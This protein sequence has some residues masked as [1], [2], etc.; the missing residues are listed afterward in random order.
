M[1]DDGT[2]TLSCFWNGDQL[3]IYHP[4]VLSGAVQSMMSLPFSTTATGVTL[5]AFSYTV[6]GAY[7]YNPSARLY[8]F[9][10][11]TIGGY[12]A[13]AADDGTSTLKATTL[14]NQLGTL[15]DCAK[16]DA[17]YGSA[18]VDFG[19]GLPGS[20]TMHH[21]FGM[22]NLH[23]TSS[24]FSTSY[25]VTV[26][27]TSSANNILPGNSGSA[28]L[29]ADGITLTRT[30]SW[31]ANWSATVTPTT[32]GVVDV[33]LMTWPFSGTTGTLT[34]SCSD[35]SGSTYTPRTVT[36]S[37]FSLAAA[38]VKSKPL[39][40]TN[41]LTPPVTTYSKVYAWDATDYQPNPVGSIPTNA[42]T[43]VTC[44]DYFNHAS[45]ACKNCPN[46]N[47]L[48]WYLSVPC[49]WDNGTINGG[50]RTRY[51]RPDGNYTKIGMWIRKKSGIPG[52]SSTTSSGVMS[53]GSIDLSTMSTAAIVA[54]NL[55]KN[56]FF[57]PAVG[58]TNADDN[59]YYDAD[60]SGDYWTSTPCSYS[61][62]A[63]HLHF[64]NAGVYFSY[65]NRICGFCLWQAQ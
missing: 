54:L 7:R 61:A 49:Y 39:A 21:L 28:I 42:N 19:T 4:Y 46:A 22:L 31:G 56:Y 41:S 59:T 38:Q 6:G 34:V 45:Y 44:N 55:Q 33:Y 29:A 60:T 40:M 53:Y 15:A 63:Y 14:A 20:L 3:N 10:S 35:G 47:E 57:L 9:S 5:A 11:N 32:N 30:G 17:L 24:T 25:P 13:I 52:F 50:N 36:L 43:S 8:A 16:Y 64:H 27:L 23:L 12:T 18:T 26:T 65:Y 2:T 51:T 48:T 37:G 1:S 58:Y 62:D